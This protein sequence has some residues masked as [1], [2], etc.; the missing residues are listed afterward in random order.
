MVYVFPVPN[1]FP[2]TAASYQ[3]KVTPAGAVAVNVAV[4]PVQTTL[5]DAVGFAGVGY[6]VMVV[7]IGVN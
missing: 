7:V 1:K 3:L 6:T 2:L 4:L 5:A